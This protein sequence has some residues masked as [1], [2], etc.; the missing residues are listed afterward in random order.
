LITGPNVA[1]E[2]AAPVM[3]L[4]AADSVL[5]DLSSTPVIRTK[6]SAQPT[7]EHSA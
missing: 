4:M 7:A 6:V 5:T 3:P 2:S 1:W